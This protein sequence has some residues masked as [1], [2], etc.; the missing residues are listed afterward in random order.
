[1]YLD[2]AAFQQKEK[3]LQKILGPKAHLWHG[4]KASARRLR[5]DLGGG[6]GCY[7]CSAASI[8]YGNFSGYATWDEQFEYTKD[9]S[10]KIK[11]GQ[12]RMKHQ[13]V[14]KSQSPARVTVT[15]SLWSTLQWIRKP[16]STMLKVT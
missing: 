11:L 6:P 10:G 4:L 15:S 13:A 9:P 8:G 2:D 12:M 1:M 5:R 16:L 14:I 3:R 7:N